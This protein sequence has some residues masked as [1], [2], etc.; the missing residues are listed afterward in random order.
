M[1]YTV[2]QITNKIN[3][4]KYIGQH[5]TSNID[6]GYMGSG[7]IIRRA[8]KKYGVDNFV[9]D[10]LFIFDNR[11]EMNTKEA[12]LITDEFLVDS[13]NITTGGRGGFHHINATEETKKVAQ[14]KT[15]Q[16][17][18][19]LTD[20]ERQMLSVKKSRPGYQNGMY[21]VS[22][23]GKD[24]PGYGKKCSAETK[25]K[26]GLANTGSTR[27]EEQRRSMSKRGKMTWSDPLYR[28]K[29]SK[30]KKDIGLR[31]PS[32]KGKLWWTDG[33]HVI[34]DYVCP[35]PVWRRGRK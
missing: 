16:H 14:A 19:S 34:R 20:E 32:P 35:G 22:R 7:T 2:Y 10:I 21:G 24:A 28:V 17:Y 3:G 26:I 5:Q 23:K 4:K 18:A 9:K 6:D 13:Y 33:L 25:L 30:I 11:E 27:T 12:E 29:M 8:V 31:P 1:F 15:K